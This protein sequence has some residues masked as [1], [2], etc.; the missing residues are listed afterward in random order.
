MIVETRERT[1]VLA[2]GIDA[3]GAEPNHPIVERTIAKLRKA[4]LAKPTRLVSVKELGLAVLTQSTLR[5]RSAP[6]T[7]W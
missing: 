5:L 2:T 6:A 1:R 4:K 3:G 7:S